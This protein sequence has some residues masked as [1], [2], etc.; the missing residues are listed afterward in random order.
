VK[1][2]QYLHLREGALAQEDAQPVDIAVNGVKHPVGMLH[3]E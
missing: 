2:G 3:V 1:E